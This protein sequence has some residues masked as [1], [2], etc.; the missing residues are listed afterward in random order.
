[1][2]GVRA[3]DGGVFS[4]N[5][6]RNSFLQYESSF[7]VLQTVLLLCLFLQS[8][9]N[10]VSPTGGA[11]DTTPPKIVEKKST[12]NFQKQFKK[13]PIFLTFDEWIKLEDAFNQV[14]VSPPLN[15]RP[16]VVLK[17][18]S[19]YFTFAKDEVLR[20][21][22]TYTINFGTAVKDNNEGNIA[23][24]LRFV[25][26][27]GDKIDSLVVRGRVVDAQTGEPTEGVLLMLYDNLSDTAVRKSRPFYFGRTDKNGEAIIE[28]V[29]EGQFKVFALVDKDFNYQYSQDQEKIGFPDSLLTVTAADVPSKILAD[30]SRRKDSLSRKPTAIDSSVQKSEGLTIRL[31]DPPK[32]WQ[33]LSRETD[34][35]GLIKL[36]TS[37]NP[38]SAKISFD[39]A[40]QIVEM[41]RTQDSI[42]VY[43]DLPSGD[44]AWN[45]Y[46]QNDTFRTDTIRVRTRGRADF[47]KK[48]TKLNPF[49]AGALS[50]RAQA[51]ISKHPTKPI[52]LS[53]ENPL[54]NIDSQKFILLD[55]TKKNTPLSIRTDSA[56]KRKLVLD[57]AWQEGM[58]YSLTVLPIALMDLYG[59]KNDS[60]VM[61]ISVRRKNEFGSL[62]IK[63]NGLDS[64]QAYLAQVIGGGDQVEASFYIN[65]KKSFET[66]VE[67]V[68]PD[69]YKLKLIEDRNRNRRWDTGDYDLKQQAERIFWKKI[70][71][72]RADWEVEVEMDLTMF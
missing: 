47:F 23:N 30:T 59:L 55:S 33:I 46:V 5:Q 4:K 61:K 29:R 56:T 6:S 57:A 72:L 34:R 25:F 48:N 18:K 45:L 3:A 38:M 50:D 70:E 49:S 7:G 27:T 54:Q 17:G 60:L 71:G 2:E 66:R 69:E 32:K 53:F 28:N 11:R 9:A 12:P 40:G 16:E 37:R 24:N 39:K 44:A 19:V 22:A 67:T 68:Q 65:Q 62:I 43:Y 52:I 51:T 63:L 41:E 58:T 20:E 15:E 14:V 10:I 31:F 35:Y 26:S 42:L 1:L 64:A 8:C 13:Q 36:Q 21:N